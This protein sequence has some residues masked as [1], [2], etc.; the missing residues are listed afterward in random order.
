MNKIK[1]LFTAATLALSLASCGGS[2][3]D[4]APSGV[5]TEEQVSNSE[6]IDALVIAAYSYLGNDHYTAPNFLWPTGNLRAGDAH[7]GGNGPGD[8]FAYH[9]LSL[10]QPIV[11]DMESFPPDLIDLNNKKWVRNYTGISR[12]NS[13]L[14]VIANA[15][16]AIENSAAKQSELRFIRSIFY[17]DLKIHHKHIP[18]IDETMTQ[19]QILSATNRE[20]SDQELWDKIAA[21]FEFAANNL[22]QTQEDVGRA[23]ALSA[24]AYLA[25]TLLYQAYEQNELHEVININKDKLVKVVALVDE[26]EEAGVYG[27]FDDYANNFLFESENGKE[28]VFAIQRSLNDGSPDGRGSWPSA[29][30]APM[31]GG[32][33]CCGFHVPTEN[34]VNAFKTDQQGLPLFG[35]FNDFNYDM[36]TD[37][38]DPRLDHTVA[39][40]GKPFKYDENLIHG[41]DS[42]ARAP[43]IYGNFTAMKD[44]EHPDCSCRG[45][46]GPF[47]IFSLNTPLIRYAEVLLW[48]AEALIELD[49]YDEALPI[50][51]RIRERAKQSTDKLH[52]AS[53]Y[54]IGLYTSFGSKEQARAALRFERRLELGLEGHRFFDLVRWGIAKETIDSYLAIEAV[55]KPYLVDAIFTK[56]KH[57]YLPIPNQQIILSGGSYTQNPGY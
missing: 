6:N 43:G 18:W 36:T 4:V 38:V 57:E 10:Y 1:T 26:I 25:K 20:L 34:F 40:E 12:A 50:I 23:S 33:G 30:N 32:F 46:N 29:L 28:S 53:I 52:N 8:I 42:W 51:N 16:D 17:F 15:P 35:S 47:P 49:R 56:G 27:L 11:P 9:A 21:D 31:A 22:P 2:D 45:E 48:K 5:L 24:K 7:K 41:G 39:M 55:R 44:L 14:A 37:S 19:D 13:A 54:N 3:L